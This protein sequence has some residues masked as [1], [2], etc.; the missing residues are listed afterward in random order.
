MYFKRS[1]LLWGPDKQF[2]QKF[3]ETSRKETHPKGF[4]LF[5]AGNPADSFF[6]D[7]A[8]QFLLAMETSIR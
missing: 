4:L 1:D 8:S 2:A 6:A 7:N 3:I 5:R